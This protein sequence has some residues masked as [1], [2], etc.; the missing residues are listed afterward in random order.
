M[1]LKDRI[2]TQAHRL[3]FEL[4]GVTSPDPPPHYE[5]YEA[6]LGSGRHGEMGYLANERAC[7]R[8]ADPRRILPECQSILVLGMR[9][10]APEKVDTQRLSEKG[11][12]CHSEGAKRPKNLLPA[13]RER[14]SSLLSVAQNDSHESF[15][16]CSQVSKGLYG[17]VSSYAWGDD[18][19]E[20]IVERLKGLVAFIEGQIGRAVANRWY[21]D[22]GPVL[23]RDLAQRAGLG[24]IGKNT[25]LINPQKGSYFFLAEILLG[26]ELT[27]DPPFEVDRCGSCMLCIEACPTNCILADRTMDASRCIS[28]LSIE[29]KSVIPPDLRPQMGD[30]VF[31]CDVCQQVCP[32]NQRFGSAAG[33]PAFS[34]RSEI[35]YPNLVEEIK[36]TPAAFNHKFKASPVKRAKRRGYLRNAAVA[37]GNLAAVYHR[38]VAEMAVEVLSNV[39]IEEPEPLVRAHAAWALGWIGGGESRSALNLAFQAERDEQ[40]HSE[41]QAAL[42]I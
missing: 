23:E 24:W 1:L 15:Q 2:K 16:T 29:L 12:F 28:Y 11:E 37:L 41:I 30:W 3:G 13:Q 36:L 22:T 10:P 40:V 5:V 4:V 14:D 31:G 9:Y 42:A 26:I 34:P 8:R 21:T 20:V 18:Y 39:L 33:D 25:C 35:P 38:E 19:H 7:R 6:W 17:R 32:W 27:V